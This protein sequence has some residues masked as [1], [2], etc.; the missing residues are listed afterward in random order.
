MELGGTVEESIFHSLHRERKVHSS[1]RHILGTFSSLTQF[2]SLNMKSKSC[3]CPFW[4]LAGEGTQKESRRLLAFCILFGTGPAR[5]IHKA[6]NGRHPCDFGEQWWM[7]LNSPPPTSE[8][9]IPTRAHSSLFRNI[10]YFRTHKVSF[11]LSPFSLSF[12]FFFFF[13]GSTNQDLTL[14]S[15]SRP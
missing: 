6:D 5:Q 4:V 2:A 1:L 12:G 8:F 7:C 15:I 9:R 11:S 10:L 13:L 14:Y 3:S